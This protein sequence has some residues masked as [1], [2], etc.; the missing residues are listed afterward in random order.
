MDT[1]QAL[2]DPVR[3]T[4]VEQLA[5]VGESPAGVLADLA[6]ER[7]GISQPTTSK[8]L[9]VLREAGVVTTSTDAQRRIY[10]LDPRP[11]AE[12][13]SWASR[14]A[15]FW[16]DRLDALEVHLRPDPSSH[17]RKEQP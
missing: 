2:A 12:M 5:Q 4:L 7:F 8:H 1:F 3:R 17:A 13:A 15:T 9:K 16:N 11:L 6:R 14:Q 10:R